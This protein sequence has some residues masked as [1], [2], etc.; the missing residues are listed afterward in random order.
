MDG[1]SG[2]A[3]M[4]CTAVMLQCDRPC[5]VGPY[6]IQWTR[7]RA[8]SASRLRSSRR[9]CSAAR[10]RQALPPIGIATSH[11]PRVRR[12]PLPRI[13]RAEADTGCRIL[14]CV[15]AVSLCLRVGEHLCEKLFGNSGLLKEEPF[16]FDGRTLSPQAPLGFIA[17]GQT[18][19]TD[20]VVKLLCSLCLCTS[21]SL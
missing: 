5:K 21:V 8:A 15:L 12:C 1:T 16:I 7:G 4:S 11:L 14:I 13:Q 18:G 9:S 6:R 19:E 3:V 20:A 10:P 2:S 17:L